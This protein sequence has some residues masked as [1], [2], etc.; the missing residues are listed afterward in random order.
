MY[1]EPAAACAC[2]ADRLRAA[3]DTRAAEDLAAVLRD[4]Q[5]R[6]AVRARAARRAGAARPV[7][8]HRHRP[9]RG[10]RRRQAEPRDA[11]GDRGRNGRRLGRNSTPSRRRRSTPAR[12]ARRSSSARPRISRATTCTGWRVRCS[13]STATRQQRRSIPASRN[14]SA[15]APLT[16]ANNY[17]FKFASG[18]VAAGQRVLVVDH[19]R[20]AAEPAGRQ[21]DQ[22]LPDQLA[23]AA[24][25]GAGPRRR[26]HV[27]RPERVA[28]NRQG[29]QLAARAEGPVPVV[30]RLYWPKPDAL[31][32]T[33]KA[34]Q[35]KA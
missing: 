25:P 13:A 4:P 27:L 33:W 14:D 8:H 20:V 26:L 28:G 24:Q 1:P 5:L 32:G 21:P 2:P 12:W 15:G 11:N 16:G 10:L 34:P 18:S 7:R 31:N 23:D 35:A 19:V 3:A 30:L 9:G 17:T 6:A 29:V 22:A